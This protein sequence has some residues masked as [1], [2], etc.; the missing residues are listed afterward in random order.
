MDKKN[1]VI[2][3]NLVNSVVVLICIA[4][5]L[6]FV[7]STKNYLNYGIFSLVARILLILNL[8][9]FGV[10]VFSKRGISNRLRVGI[11]FI[12]AMFVCAMISYFVTPRGAI[13]D[14]LIVVLCYL[15]IP[16]YMVVSKEIWLI[17][18]TRRIISLFAI[19]MALF[20]IYLG[21]FQPV[22]RPGTQALS[23]GYSNSNRAGTYLMLVGIL[24]SVCAENAKN[25]FREFLYWGLNAVLLYLIILTQCR[26]AFIIL[27]SVLIYAMLPNRPKVGK[28]FLNICLL[29]SIVFSWVYVYIYNQGWL[30]NLEI[31]GKSIYSGRQELYTE[32]F[33]GFSLFGKSTVNGFVGLNLG[34]GLLNCLGIVGALLFYSFILRFNAQ[35]TEASE[36]NQHENCL[37]VFAMGMV[38][39]HACTEVSLFTGGSVYASMMGLILIMMQDNSVRHGVLR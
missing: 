18:D 36:L 2:H 30:I 27:A 37:N 25:R 6:L 8:V 3:T 1:F 22:Y 38:L 5:S 32:E 4:S 19:G 16:I 17:E 33:L 34:I 12:V 10:T 21:F 14:Y 11:L 20:F 39:L 35:H 15:S 23:F 9:L 29:I 28:R 31:F 7:F 26:T 24:L 13:G